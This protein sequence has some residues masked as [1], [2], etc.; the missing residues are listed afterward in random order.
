M[1]ANCS[2]CSPKISDASESLRSLT[3]NEQPWAICSGRS[4]EMS[5][6]E[7]IDQVVHQKLANEWIAHFFER[8]AHL[9]IF[10]Q[11]TSNLLG[12]RMSEVP[13]LF[14]MSNVSKSLRSLIKN[15]QCEQI[16]QVAHQNRAPMSKSLRSLTK[17]SEWANCSFFLANRS[18]ANF[19]AKNE[20]FAQKNNEQ[21][22]NPASMA[23]NSTKQNKNNKKWL[24]GGCVILKT[25]KA[26]NSTELDRIIKMAAWR[27]HGS[28]NKYSRKLY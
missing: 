18:F 28:D 17:T 24:P 20:R 4:G 16:A 1:W 19:F 2:G 15:E 11:K 27:P 23:G 6:H 13:A 10:G 22:P 26:S 5:D 25:N 21:S 12:N 8:I 3:K 9:L 14:L 7:R